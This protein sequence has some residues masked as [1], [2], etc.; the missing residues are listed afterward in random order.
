[1]LVFILDYSPKK[2]KLKNFLKKNPRKP[3]LGPLSAIFAQ[4]LAK[5]N[6]PGKKGS[7][8]F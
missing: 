7:V 6:F 8:S 1:M 2:I 4:I 3:I 5:M